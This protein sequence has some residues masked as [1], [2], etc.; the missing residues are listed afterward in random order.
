MASVHPTNEPVLGYAPGSPERKKLQVEL[1]NQMNTVIEIPCIINGKEIF[2]GNTITQVVPHNHGHVLAQVHMAGRNE[3]EAACNA[4]VNAQEEW[5]NIGLEA[6]CKI[7]EKCA[8]MLSGDWR[9]KINAA[10][11]LNQ[12]KT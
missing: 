10:T 11:M 3:M 1:D 5:I 4:A 7:F 12:S 2:T 9:M 8:D 6:R